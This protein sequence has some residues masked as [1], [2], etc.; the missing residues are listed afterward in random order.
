MLHL[1]NFL[2]STKTGSC[3]YLLFEN[4]KRVS[5]CTHVLTLQKFDSTYHHH[6]AYVIMNYE[7]QKV[8]MKYV[9]QEQ[10]KSVF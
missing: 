9:R 10:F 4:C 6:N 7:L 8:G 1:L 3:E 5:N 2:S